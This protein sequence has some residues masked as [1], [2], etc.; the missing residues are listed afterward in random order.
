MLIWAAFIFLVFIFLALDLGVLNKKD[1][2]I[3][4]KEASIWTALWFTVAMSFSGVIY[5]LKTIFIIILSDI[6]FLFC[7]LNP[8][9]CGSSL[10]HCL[11]APARKPRLQAPAQASVQTSVQEPH[12]HA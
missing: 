2:I 8:A 12:L 1:H 7:K 6:C 9:L 5:C 4:S 10:T 11:Q 3:R